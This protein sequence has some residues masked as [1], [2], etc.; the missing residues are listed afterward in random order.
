MIPVCL[1]NLNFG[2][3]YRKHQVNAADA[4]SQ[5]QL[6]TMAFGSLP[7]PSD[8]HIHALLVVILIRRFIGRRKL[9]LLICKN[10]DHQTVLFFI[11]RRR[12]Q[13]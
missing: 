8:Y 7:T 12:F 3:K 10:S 1:Q 9:P 6:A 2:K 5:A 11:S 4:K 13:V